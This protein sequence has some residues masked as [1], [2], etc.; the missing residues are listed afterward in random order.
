MIVDDGINEQDNT[1]SLNNLNDNSPLINKESPFTFNENSSDMIT[2][3]A[4]IDADNNS[5]HIAYQVLM[6]LL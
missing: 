6:H 4:A 1:I 3:I 2:Q 5:P